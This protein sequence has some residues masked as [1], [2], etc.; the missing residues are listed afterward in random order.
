MVHCTSNDR[1]LIG[2][3]HGR[4]LK[5]DLKMQSILPE[6]EAVLSVQRLISR[7]VYNGVSALTWFCIFKLG[8]SVFGIFLCV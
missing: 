1:I 5:P 6:C 3:L 7:F 8:G 4:F 2:V